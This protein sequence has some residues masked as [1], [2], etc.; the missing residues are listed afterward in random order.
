MV[1]H[2][3]ILNNNNIIATVSQPKKTHTQIQDLDFRLDCENIR[4]SS[5]NVPSGGC[6]RR[7]TFDMLRNNN[8]YNWKSTKKTHKTLTFQMLRT[9]FFTFHFSFFPKTKKYFECHV[10]NRNR[11]L[12]GYRYLEWICDYLPLG[13]NEMHECRKKFLPDSE[14]PDHCANRVVSHQVAWR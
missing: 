12:N 9:T 10:S 5:R 4:F 7:L 13:N 3:L 14:M 11:Q 2:K 8:Y 6:F 1:F